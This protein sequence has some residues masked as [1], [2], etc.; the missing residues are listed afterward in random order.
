MRRRVAF[1]L[2]IL[3]VALPTVGQAA[4][5]SPSEL[6]Y[7]QVAAL[8]DSER[9]LITY[10]RALQQLDFART[11]KKISQRDYVRINHDLN[12]FIEAEAHYQNEL[13]TK[14]SSFPEDEREVLGNIEKYA[15][16]VPLYILAMVV[17]GARGSSFSFSP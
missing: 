10:D 13:L 11:E 2:T 5:K 3:G 4:V 8:Q 15:V 7:P 1:L 12:G 6:T 16:E 17:G 9:R 14:H